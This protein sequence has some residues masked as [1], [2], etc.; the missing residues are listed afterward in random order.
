MSLYDSPHVTPT[1]STHSENGA[2]VHEICTLTSEFNFELIP[3]FNGSVGGQSLVGFHRLVGRGG[4][5]S[6]ELLSPKYHRLDGSNLRAPQ[7][8]FRES[9]TIFWNQFLVF[10]ALRKKIPE[11]K[12][13]FA[14]AILAHVEFF[15][16]EN[17]QLCSKYDQA[18]DFGAVD[19]ALQTY[20][21]YARDFF[22]S[23]L[24]ATVTPFRT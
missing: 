17:I 20:V 10:Q 11:Q 19:E 1:I 18:V 13:N 8:T 6:L 23:Y 4:Y 15:S 12:L 21:K 5:R 7:I 9:T 24:W 3:N 22:L 14:H 16:P 2:A